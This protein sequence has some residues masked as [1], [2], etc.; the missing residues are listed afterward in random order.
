MADKIYKIF[1]KENLFTNDKHE[2]LCLLVTH[3]RKV[4]KGT[5]YSLKYN[6]INF[7]ENLT[8]PL[9]ECTIKL[10]LS[11]IPHFSYEAEYT[12]WLAGFIEK[13]T[14]GGQREYPQLK[15]YINELQ[16]VSSE[17]QNHESSAI[18]KCDSA[19]AISKYFD[20]NAYK[21]SRLKK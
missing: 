2:N 14:V 8:S 11:L 6:Y 21:K 19:E 5:E 12:L 20:S 7:S 13:I 15:K 10:D 4:L 16:N 9:S 1:K 17:I 3:I 18:N